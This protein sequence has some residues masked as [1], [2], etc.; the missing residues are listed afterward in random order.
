VTLR[1]A[2]A[3][4]DTAE[5][6][7]RASA[8]K[9]CATTGNVMGQTFREVKKVSIPRVIDPLTFDAGRV[10]ATAQAKPAE[11]ASPAPRSRW[12]GRSGAV[13]A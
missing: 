3:Q 2:E 12:P 13:A 8:A 4:N 1:G 5:A 7:A 10:R 6:P 11:R 9:V